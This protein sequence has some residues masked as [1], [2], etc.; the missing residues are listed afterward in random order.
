[1]E[2]AKAIAKEEVK[3]KMD[4]CIVHTIERLDKGYQIMYRV[5]SGFN[6]VCPGVLFT[7]DE[8]KA[9]CEKYNYNIVAVGDFWQ[10][11]E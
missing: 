11:L 8:A 5:R 4:V 6:H 7:L 1:M 3:Q 10:C 9:E 2:A